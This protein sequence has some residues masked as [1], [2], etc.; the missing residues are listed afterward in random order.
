MLLAY[1]L[2]KET[3]NTLMTLYKSMKAMVRSPG[4]DF[5][6][7]VAGV[8]QGDKSAPYFFIIF[9]DYVLRTLID[10]IKENGITLLKKKPRSRRYPA[11]IITGA[12][13]ADDLALLANALAQAEPLLQR[14]R[15]AAG[16]MA[17]TRTQIKQ[18]TCVLNEKKSSPS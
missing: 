5:F 1:G 10:I 2:T 8:L 13:Y 6:D 14:L 15:Q 12:N 3:V 9:L 11:E 17:S 18:C 4:R 16:G 7:I